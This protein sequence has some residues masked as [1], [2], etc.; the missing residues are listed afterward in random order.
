[1]QAQKSDPLMPT[2]F[3]EPW[4]LDAATGGSYQEVTV[5]AAG[6]VVGRY[7]FTIARLPARQM[8]CGMPDLAH[9]LGPAIDA[10]EGAPVNRL[11]RHDGILR[12][13]LEKLPASSGVY[14]KLHRGTTNTLVF[15]ELGY[16]T[17]VQFSYD[18]RPA[19]EQILWSG[20]RDK[21]RNVIRRAK[22]QHEVIDL[23]DP[24]LFLSTYK[25]NLQQRGRTNYYD[26]LPAVCEQVVSRKRGRIL[27]AIGADGKVAASIMYIW[28]MQAAYYL[29][30]TRQLTA[31]NGAISLLL[32]TAIQDTARRGLVFDFDGLA[33][34]GSRVF[35]TGFG[36]SVVPRYIVS[37]YS[38]AHRIAGRLSNPFR[39]PTKQYFQW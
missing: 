17:A 26:R 3:H 22:E 8:L 36:G 25:E 38:L 6:R 21:T 11:L 19:P 35:Y 12:E 15:Q 13:L 28:D 30:S 23:D 4:F 5:S 16:R 24:G 27:A 31:G 2:V 29:L 34:P 1:M 18:I 7:P 33:G 39:L 32:W 14:H 37:R 20:M 9:F 10:G